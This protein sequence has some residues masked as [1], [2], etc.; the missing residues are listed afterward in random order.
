MAAT[1][2]EPLVVKVGGAEI[3]RVPALLGELRD[4]ARPCVLVHGGGGEITRRLLAVGIE[5]AFVEGRRVTTPKAAKV[6]HD[7]LLELQSTIA[8][9]ALQAGLRPS[10]AQ[11]LFT[12]APTRD[13]RLGSVGDVSQVDVP[14]FERMLSSGR[15][16]VAS[17]TGV[18]PDG[19]YLNINADD[20]AG[21]IAGALGAD[22]MLFTDVPAVRG[23]DGEIRLLDGARVSELIAGGHVKGGMLAKL[24]AALCALKR[25]AHSA[26]IGRMADERPIAAASGGGTKLVL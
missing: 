22:L 17:S 16:A 20:L 13:R 10:S 14:D 6:A 7:A 4:L 2:A 3:P 8:D 24:D 21:A 9:L 26:W 12:L 1:G 15:L 5:S 18:G 11:H 25:G 19:A 23:P